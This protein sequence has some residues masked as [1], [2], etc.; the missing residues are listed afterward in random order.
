MAFLS[1]AE[2][3]AEETEFLL[4]SPG[5]SESDVGKQQ[6]RLE[7]LSQ[8]SDEHM[9]VATESD[10]IF[11][12]ALVS[13]KPFQRVRHCFH[14][15]LGVLQ[16]RWGQGV[17]RSLLTSVEAWAEAKGASRLELTVVSSNARAI[18]L[19]KSCGYV[20]EGTRRN[21]MYIGGG[22]QDELYMAKLLSQPVAQQVVAPDI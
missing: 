22:Y 11:G 1:F 3:L 7:R 17:G 16:S 4:L 8:S 13:R 12:F 9:E 19:Y 10:Q 5:E 2:K 6:S 14:I 20:P 15:A 18:A 21:S